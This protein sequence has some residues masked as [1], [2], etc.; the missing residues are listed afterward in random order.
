MRCIGNSAKE[1]ERGSND[2]NERKFGWRWPGAKQK[3]QGNIESK[4]V[5]H[6]TK[7]QTTEVQREEGPKNREKSGIDSRMGICLKSSRKNWGE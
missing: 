4:K 2:M 5:K 7:E 3:G 6:L 1:K